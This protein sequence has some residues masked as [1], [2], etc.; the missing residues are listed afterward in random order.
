MYNKIK[1]SIKTRE[2]KK[3][4]KFYFIG[5]FDWYCQSLISGKDTGH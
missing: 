5:F 4:F 2:E 3:S 1:K